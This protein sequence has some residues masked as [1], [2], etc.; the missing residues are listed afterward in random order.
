MLDWLLR[1]SYPELWPWKNSVSC[2]PGSEPAEPIRTSEHTATEPPAGAEHR[3][4][5]TE[6][7]TQRATKVMRAKELQHSLMENLGKPAVPE[8]V[9]RAQSVWTQQN[10]GELG[11]QTYTQRE[12]VPSSWYGPFQR[13]TSA[14]WQ[15][16]WKHNL[17]FIQNLSN[18]LMCSDSEDSDS[19]LIVASCF[20]KRNQIQFVCSFLFFCKCST[21]NMWVSADLKHTTLNLV[22]STEIKNEYFSLL[23]KV[24]SPHCL[25]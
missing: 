12:W 20:K 14:E 2:F 23:L 18:V 10:Q 1:I 13:M 5:S 22:V 25:Y 19:D 21:W 8:V 7:R 16:M 9:W 4:W 15:I 3:M 17:H 11:L 24:L 6:S